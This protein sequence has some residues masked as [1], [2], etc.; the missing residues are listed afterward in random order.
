MNFLTGLNESTLSD[1]DSDHLMRAIEAAVARAIQATSV[2]TRR[3]FTAK[4]AAA[5]LTLSEREIYKL[6]TRKELIPVRHGKRLM[7]D[8]RDLDVWIADRKA[9]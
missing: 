8:V 6:I 5:Y 4:D 7:L 1:G 9:A 2:A 3:L